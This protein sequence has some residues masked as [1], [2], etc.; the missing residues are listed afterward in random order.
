MEKK[1]AIL[2]L[3]VFIG[4]LL[5]PFLALAGDYQG[6]GKTIHYEGLVPCGK[7]EAGPDED[8]EVTKP[9]EFCHLFVML[10]GIIDFV[11]I[12]ILPPVVVLMMVIAGIMFFFAGG[13]PA[14]LLQAKKL[15]TSVV[16]GVVII[17]SAYLI[18]GTVL[19]VAGVQSWATLDTW[20][21]QG[22]FI[23]NCPIGEDGDDVVSGEE[24]EGD[25]ETPGITEEEIEEMKKEIEE[26]YPDLEGEWVEIPIICPDWEE[27]CDEAYGAAEC[28]GG[29][30]V[31]DGLCIP[32]WPAEVLN[33]PGEIMGK[34]WH[35][36]FGSE[37]VRPAGTAHAYC[38]PE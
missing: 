38:V 35:C 13:N 19:T 2:L 22:T 1:I 4:G 32:T 15:I 3:V 33:P 17:F 20:L 11:L 36:V 12:D 37:E 30:N 6:Y 21:S 29:E 8:P 34:G 14:L 23:V 5:F 27:E 10:D 24:E 25:E 31:M 7:S 9:C 28:K 26:K 18:I 16:I